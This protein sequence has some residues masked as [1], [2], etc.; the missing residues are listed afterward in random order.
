MTE[1]ISWNEI[2]KRGI[3]PMISIKVVPARTDTAYSNLI[4]IPKKTARKFLN[5]MLNSKNSAYFELNSP[6]LDFLIGIIMEVT[7]LKRKR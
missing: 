5:P 1:N 7:K 4:L 3:V 6:G 2:A